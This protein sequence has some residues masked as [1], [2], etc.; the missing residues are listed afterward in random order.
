MLTLF[1]YPSAAMLS[2]RQVVI[3]QGMALHA[4]SVEWGTRRIARHVKNTIFIQGQRS[5]PYQPT[6]PPNHTHLELLWRHVDE[7][8]GAL[9]RGRVADEVKCR[10]ARLAPACHKHQHGLGWGVHL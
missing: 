5:S 1:N 8:C 2:S 4:P 9:I 7:L 10:E 3:G 6:P